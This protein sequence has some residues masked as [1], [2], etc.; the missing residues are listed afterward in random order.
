MQ[1]LRWA[2]PTLDQLVVVHGDQSVVRAD[3]GSGAGPVIPC[4]DLGPEKTLGIPAEGSQPRLRAEH[5]SAATSFW[6]SGDGVERTVASAGSWG[7]LL[8]SQPLGSLT[9]CHAGSRKG[10]W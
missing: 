3:H 1:H 2:H 7:Y 6:D 4:P 8:H 5:T 10:S 9:P